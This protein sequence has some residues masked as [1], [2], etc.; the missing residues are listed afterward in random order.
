M[1]MHQTN[2]TRYR[3][4]ELGVLLARYYPDAAPHMIARTV[5]DMQAA[6][7]TAKRQRRA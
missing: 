5:F 4:A 6:A 7:R 1:Q 2:D 3:A